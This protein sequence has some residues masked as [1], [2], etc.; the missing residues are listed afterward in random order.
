MIESES[1]SVDAG[2]V[3]TVSL[4]DVE[5]LLTN[6]ASSSSVPPRA[7]DQLL[8]E[9]RREA[10]DGRVTFAQLCGAS[11]S[12][13]VLPSFLAEASRLCA[14]LNGDPDPS[15]SQGSSSL[16]SPSK[17]LYQLQRDNSPPLQ[18]SVDSSVDAESILASLPNRDRSEGNDVGLREG[19]L[20]L[21][22]ERHDLSRVDVHDLVS[23]TIVGGCNVRREREEIDDEE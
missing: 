11:R 19:L 4:A 10:P 3:N 5:A 18:R 6:L 17:T 22:N 7:T 9:V 12:L 21:L 16:G 2:P 20:Y 13:A 8:Q 23:A 1:G 14:K 15:L